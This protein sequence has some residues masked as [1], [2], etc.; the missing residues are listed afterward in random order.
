LGCRFGIVQAFILEQGLLHRTQ[1]NRS[2]VEVSLAGRNSTGT[3]YKIVAEFADNVKLLVTTRNGRKIEIY[4]RSN[5]SLRKVVESSLLG[6]SVL[7]SVKCGE[8]LFGATRAEDGI[9]K[10][11]A[12]VV[13]EDVAGMAHYNRP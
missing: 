7:S 2:R 8:L 10:L 11:K 1:K 12:P 5:G 6:W 4:C 9:D 13:R 3:P